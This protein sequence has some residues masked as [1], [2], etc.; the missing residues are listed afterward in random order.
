MCL[1]G[2]NQRGD[3]G[4]QRVERDL[5][6]QERAERMQ[7]LQQRMRNYVDLMSK[8][9]PPAEKIKQAEQQL[10]QTMG[11]DRFEAFKRHLPRQLKRAE[12]RWTYRQ[13][14][15]PGG[16]RMVR[17]RRGTRMRGRPSR[18]R[19]PREEPKR[20][21]SMHVREGKLVKEKARKYANYLGD[22]MQ[23]QQKGAAKQAKVQAQI[24]ELL[25]KFE[26]LIVERFEGDRAIAKKAKDGKPVFLKK[27]RA[28]WASFFKKFI[29]RTIKKK[30]P[31]KNI[32]DFMFRGMVPR[33]AKG[34]VISDMTL[35][36]GRIERFVRFSI[37]AD[38]MAK[39]QKFLPGDRFGKDM[40]SGEELYYL[41]LAVA[42]GR[43][44][45]TAPKPTQGM[46]MAG[47]AEEKAAQELGLPMASRLDRKT[48]DLRKGKGGFGFSGKDKEILEET[49]YRFV[50]WWHWGNLKPGGPHRSTTVA[51]Y[52]A[53]G[54][55]VVLGI[56]AIT[57]N[58]LK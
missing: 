54:V 27:T 55:I 40:L 30:V 2:G 49:P 41:A 21:M 6:P 14:R 18:R 46:F 47:A 57:V 38:A 23:G 50:P 8:R 3:G 39:L 20:P 19:G 48:S 43:K 7:E 51:F 44:Y 42:R 28:Q 37:L 29:G 56:L 24:K 36:S 4:K 15:L 53:L 22:R 10:S 34:V 11:R 32:R 31:T 13:F 9:A 52:V 25:S 33:G 58:L 16:R 45:K 17:D 5:S 26:K 1:A 12:G 35:A